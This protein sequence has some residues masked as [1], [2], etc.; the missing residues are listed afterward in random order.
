MTK[1][2]HGCPRNADPPGIGDPTPLVETAIG[3]EFVDRALEDLA[4][5][6]EPDRVMAIEPRAMH[7][8]F[9]Q[10]GPETGTGQLICKNALISLD[11]R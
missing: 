9:R 6:A 11:D 4:E 7:V 1:P 8:C 5:P 2:A 3:R 10:D